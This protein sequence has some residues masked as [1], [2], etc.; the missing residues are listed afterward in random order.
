MAGA[1][2]SSAG[3]SNGGSAGS[4]DNAG[5][6]GGT[7]GTSVTTDRLVLDRASLEFYILPTDS[8]RFAVT[9]YDPD[10]RTCATIVWMSAA[11]SNMSVF[12]DVFDAGASLQNPYVV[13]TTDT[14]GP[15]SENDWDY[16]G[17]TTTTNSTG[18]VEFT[19]WGGETDMIDVELG[20]EGTLFTG[21]IVADNRPEGMVTFGFEYTADLPE[22]IYVQSMGMMSVPE[23]LH[24]TKDGAPVTLFEDCGVPNCELERGVCGASIPIANNITAGGLQGSR[25]VDWDGRVWTYDEANDCVRSAPASAGTYELE[26][27]YGASASAADGTP[28]GS[29]VD[30]PLT[31]RT[32]EFTLPSE[33][34]VTVTVNNGG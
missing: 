22:D 5:G 32:R 13:L 3:A 19:G 8:V 11:P 29:V 16:A 20:V 7:G 6:T 15:C 10:A 31:C 17:N 34:L 12:C 4:G 30:E 21:T 14:D 33:E 24:V 28:S 1:S 25:Y 9:G 27:C 18:C 2:G 23:W 26:V